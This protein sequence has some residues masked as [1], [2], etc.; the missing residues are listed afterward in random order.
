[1][2]PDATDRKH[3]LASVRLRLNG[4]RLVTLSC[5]LVVLTSCSEEHAEASKPVGPSQALIEKA[6]RKWALIDLP[7]TSSKRGATLTSTAGGILPEN[8]TVFPVQIELGDSSN[9]RTG[10][11]TV[12]LYFFQDEFEQWQFF[13]KDSPEHM[14]RIE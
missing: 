13:P 4:W 11:L 14:Q 9:P 2:I 7:I 6:A 8:T 1:V 5:L 3:H 12:V 10:G